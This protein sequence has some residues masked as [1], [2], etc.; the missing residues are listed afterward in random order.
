MV[1]PKE[2]KILNIFGNQYIRLITRSMINVNSQSPNGDIVSQNVQVT[3]EGYLVDSDELF[4]FLGLSDGTVVSAIRIDE[5]IHLELI[6]PNEATEELVEFLQNMPNKDK[7][8]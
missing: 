1:K 2:D 5:V 4:Y 8:N 6:D 7:M 3:L